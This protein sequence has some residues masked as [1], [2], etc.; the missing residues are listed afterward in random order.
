MHRRGLVHRDVKPSNIIFVKGHAK[1]ADIGL[2]AH[3]GEK[4]HWGTEG[5]IPPEG[6]GK[7]QADLYSLGMYCTKLAL[8][9]IDWSI[10]ICQQ[11][12]TQSLSAKRFLN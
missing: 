2:V 9:R 6:P 4:S 1:L 10:R 12:S 8:A 5:Y 7:P 11:T 3:T